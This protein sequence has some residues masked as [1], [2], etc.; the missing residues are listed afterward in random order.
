ML[1]GDLVTWGDSFGDLPRSLGLRG[2]SDFDFASRSERVDGRF[3]ACAADGS[4]E[5]GLS[6]HISA[7]EDGFVVE[8]IR[9]PCWLAF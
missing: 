3:G 5:G 2:R 7:I 8:W 4:M 9:K 1:D 6:S